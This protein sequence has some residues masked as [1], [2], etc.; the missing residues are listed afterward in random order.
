VPGEYSDFFRISDD[1]DH[2]YGNLLLLCY[3][4]LLQLVFCLLSELTVEFVVDFVA[5]SAGSF[6][7]GDSPA[8]GKSVV[9]V[10]AAAAADASYVF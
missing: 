5:G 10:G 7:A 2:D 4:D 9:E 1:I 3:C 8:G 6:P